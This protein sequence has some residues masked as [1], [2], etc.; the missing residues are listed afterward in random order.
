[1]ALEKIAEIHGVTLWLFIASLM[2]G[3]FVKN[4]GLFSAEFGSDL[5][6]YFSFDLTKPF[7][8]AGLTLVS[9]FFVHFTLPHLMSNYL[10][11][12][13]AGVYLEKHKSRTYALIFILLVHFM[14]LLAELLMFKTLGGVGAINGAEVSLNQET[15]FMLGSS[16]VAFA[17]LSFFLLNSKKI[18]IYLIVLIAYSTYVLVS[19]DNSSSYLPHLFGWILGSLIYVYEN[20]K[21][22]K[23]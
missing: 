10:I 17:L 7:R 5:L 3:F 21:S 20:K 18:F 8:M 2:F 9:S 4:Q 12:L 22:S 19:K 13:P 6:R 15:R 14:V 16:G 11:I 23:E 1:M